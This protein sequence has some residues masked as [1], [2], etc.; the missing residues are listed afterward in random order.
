MSDILYN[1]RTVY[2]T[3]TSGATQGMAAMSGAASRLGG[4]LD[5][6]KGAARA[7]L[8]YGMM[9]GSLAAVGAIGLL[10]HGIAN[11]NGE[12]DSTAVGIAGMVQAAQVSGTEGAAGWAS[13]MGFAEQA[14]AQIRV[15]AA[16]LPGTAE[17]FIEVFRAGLAPAIESGMAATDVARFTNRFGAVAIALRV[18]APQAGRDLN[19]I[20]Q[21]RAGAHVNMWN[22]LKS[23][24]GKTAAEFNAMSASARRMAVDTAMDHYQPMIDAYANT[25]EAI[26]STTQSYGREVLRIA[27]APAFAVIKKELQSVN[28]WWQANQTLINE[29]A[30]GIGT[31]L[32][33][34]YKNAHGA[35]HRLFGV[36]DAWTAGPMGQRVLG[37]GDSL[38]RG[39]SALATSAGGYVSQN[40]GEAAGLAAG[41]AGLAMGVPGLGLAAGGLVA[42]AG[43]TEAANQTLGNL[44]HAGGSILGALVGLLPVVTALDNGIG[45]FLAGSL[46]GVTHGI[47]TLATEASKAVDKMVP[48][49]SGMLVA[50]NPV[51]GLLGEMVGATGS[52]IGDVLGGAANTA[53]G[54][55]SA[56]ARTTGGFTTALGRWLNEHGVT[57]SSVGSAGTWVRDNINARVLGAAG[58][59]VAQLNQELTGI[60][61][62]GVGWI[63]HAI[64][65][66][67]FRGADASAG[68]AAN[69]RHWYARANQM[70]GGPNMDAVLYGRRGGTAA[71][72]AA[73]PHVQTLGERMTAAV[74]SFH[75]TMEGLRTPLLGAMQTNTL[76]GSV[77][78]RRATAHP[79]N[80]HVTVHIHQTINTNDDP[81]R[82]LY[83][84]RRGVHMGLYAPL[85]S[86]SVRVTH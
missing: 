54:A 8:G 62:T 71:E 81:D 4:V 70:L 72:A 77:A 60:L 16:A 85:E 86:S 52:L 61:Q 40:P 35:A 34:A 69:Y 75:S 7:V 11:V 10:A 38:R 36:M 73:A 1:V 30:N 31:R 80:T 22:R 21:G 13:S 25:W 49:I 18:D 74:N 37:L 43:H 28:N 63:N 46:P 47:D 67:E 39:A 66:R 55:L 32:V 33:N 79:G 84:T 27:T 68:L 48:S 64:T 45:T 24:I 12:L 19:L 23:T 53:A 82:V 41:A 44:G 20:L 58:A 83:L 3:E 78:A 29:V 51:F 9:A 42:F 2:Q 26:S 59:G 6:L 50:L 56:M 14:M 76:G 15:D 17:D 5:G 57:S 65:G